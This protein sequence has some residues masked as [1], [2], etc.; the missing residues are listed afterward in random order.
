MFKLARKVGYLLSTS[1]SF[2]LYDHDSLFVL[3]Y[4]SVQT[5]A[6]DCNYSVVTV[7]VSIFLIVKEA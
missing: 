2:H 6:S 5:N 4:C 1:E 3:I 7:L